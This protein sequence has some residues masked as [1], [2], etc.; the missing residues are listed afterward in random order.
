M[1]NF[2]AILNGLIEQNINKYYV[3]SSPYLGNGPFCRR[4][5]TTMDI[6]AGEKITIRFSSLTSNTNIRVYWIHHDHSKY[7]CHT[8]THEHLQHKMEFVTTMNVSLS[9]GQSPRKWKLFLWI[10]VTVLYILHFDR[11]IMWVCACV[12]HVRIR[13]KT[14]KSKVRLATSCLDSMRSCAQFRRVV[15]IIS[16][17]VGF[18]FCLCC[19]LWLGPTNRLLISFNTHCISFVCA[20]LFI[21]SSHKNAYN[22]GNRWQKNTNTRIFRANFGKNE[23]KRR[24]RFACVFADACAC[25]RFYDHNKCVCM[26][27]CAW[28]VAWFCIWTT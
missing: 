8:H 1:S 9:P 12:V 13:W 21:S 7:F 18:C 10:I 26:R 27:V 28:L 20:R 11:T 4:C 14:I 23:R 19:W 2:A 17:V 3:S 6:F 22:N 16:F 5:A 25:V 15:V 24:S